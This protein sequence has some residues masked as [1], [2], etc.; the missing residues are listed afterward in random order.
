MKQSTADTS[1]DPLSHLYETVDPFTEIK[2]PLYE[3]I[4]KAAS[5]PPSGIEIEECPAYGLIK[6][7]Q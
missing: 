7:A 4:S 3:E 5:F 6:G 1:S 2:M